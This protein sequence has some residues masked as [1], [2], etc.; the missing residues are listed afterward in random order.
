[1][2]PVYAKYSANSDKVLKLEKQVAKYKRTTSGRPIYADEVATNA[3]MRLLLDKLLDGSGSQVLSVQREPAERVG[4]LYKHEFDVQLHT[5]Y[6][7]FL[8]YL[9]AIGHLKLPV[10]Y[11]QMQY[12]VGKYPD[13]TVDLQLFM[14]MRKA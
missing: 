2:M 12:T 1:V 6:F 11:Q 5:S 13:A 7:K 4:G 14:L 3:D 10:Y 8:D 9:Q